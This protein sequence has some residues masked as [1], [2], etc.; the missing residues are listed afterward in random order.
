MKGVVISSAG[1]MAGNAQQPHNGTPPREKMLLHAKQMLRVSSPHL[2]SPPLQSHFH[3]VCTPHPH[4][5]QQDYENDSFCCRRRSHN[6]CP[7]NGAPLPGT[8]ETLASYGSPNNPP[9]HLDFPACHC[10]N[11]CSLGALA[12]PPPQPLPAGNQR[13][14]HGRHPQQVP[15][16]RGH[17]KG[18]AASITDQK[19][20]ARP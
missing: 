20:C 18:A 15:A 7:D 19:A 11:G 6:L 14:S 16:P 17:L 3:F 8:T 9:P 12:P 1:A 2:P 10:A 13:E 5:A 4:P